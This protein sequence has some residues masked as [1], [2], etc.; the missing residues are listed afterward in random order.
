M[1]FKPRGHVY[2]L[3]HISTI[4]LK[5]T[6]INGCLFSIAEYCMFLLVELAFI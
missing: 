1:N 6:F 3:S 2:T 5:K 4:R